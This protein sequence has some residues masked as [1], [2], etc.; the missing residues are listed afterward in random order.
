VTFNETP[1]KNA[2]VIDLEPQADER[3]FFARIWCER[4]SAMQGLEPHLVQ[5]SIVYNAR[6][7]TLRGMHYQVAPHGEVK[8]VRCTRG[9]LFDVI[10]DL[11][12]DSPTF[13]KHWNIE[14]S[15]RNR[16]AL[17]IPPGFAQGYQTLEDDTDVLYQMSE[18]YVPEAQRGVRWNDPAFRIEWPSAERRTISPRDD[19]YG[20]FELEAFL[21]GHVQ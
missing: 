12:P 19:A 3:G 14:L 1:L 18:F 9:A 20:D 4:E 17:Y 15:A 11:R 2:F 5:S 10:L 13:L 16:R 7:H 21:R 8:V 6:K